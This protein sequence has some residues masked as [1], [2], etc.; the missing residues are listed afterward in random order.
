MSY[1]DCLQTLER[2]LESFLERAIAAK[3]HRLKVLNGINRLDDIVRASKHRDDITETMG[4]WFAEHT[5][6]LRENSLRKADASRIN[7][8]LTE[9]KDVLSTTSTSTPAS[10]KIC[11]EIDRWRVG[12]VS[13]KPKLV[14]KRGPELR[15]DEAENTLAVFEGV[16][17][18]IADLYADLSGGRPHILSVLNDTLLSAEK[19]MN[20]EA[21]LL[22]ALMIYYLKQNGYKVE[23]FVKRLK[24]AEGVFQGLKEHA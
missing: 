11:S 13:A 5:S 23:P 7:E 12:I 9:I 15:G 18:R 21:L 10:D 22:S 6:W 1:A 17:K 2:L 19:Q 14:L 24:K 8:M 4:N 20:I 3:E 16:L